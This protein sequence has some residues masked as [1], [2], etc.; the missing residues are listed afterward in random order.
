M[1]RR[2]AD[3]LIAAL[4][5]DAIADIVQRHAKLLK[6]DP[7]KFGAHSLRAGFLTSSDA[8]GI[9]LDDTMDQSGHSSREVASRYIRHA[10]PWNKG[11]AR[12]AR[13][14]KT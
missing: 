8:A 2:R 12:A 6:L 3:G 1:R 11:R 9:P 7:E 10:N 5:P 4:T 13:S 14:L